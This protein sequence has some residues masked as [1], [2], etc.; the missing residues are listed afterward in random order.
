MLE[1][2]NASTK[3][4][5]RRDQSFVAK[6]VA[7]QAGPARKLDAPGRE[8]AELARIEAAGF[9]AWARLERFL[10]V[11]AEDGACHPGGAGPAAG[12]AQVVA[13]C[14][15]EDGFQTIDRIV[16][17][18]RSG[19]AP[20]NDPALFSLAAAAKLGDE[21][22]RRAA[23]AALPEVCRSAAHLMQWVAYAQGF[24]GWGR[25][26]RKAVGA[27]FNARP[28]A[29]LADQ[30][31][32]YPSH[33]GWS[34]RDLLRLAHPRAASASHDRLFAWAVR[35]E[36]PEGARQ[37][38]ACAVIVAIDEL[39]RT[40]D[41]LAAARIVAERRVPRASVPAGLLAHPAVSDALPLDGTAATGRDHA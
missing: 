16:D 3:P 23:Y 13:S 4:T 21:P 9:D 2:T 32:R 11:G 31:A 33:D 14:L 40:A 24:G 5:P 17:A 30:L 27:W 22:T 34:I 10:A 35:G 18:S 36:L 38:P 6:A 19:R 1:L 39:R 37:D 7:A 15:A 25:G 20:R 29:E 8:A 12:D 28:A 41:P 26:M